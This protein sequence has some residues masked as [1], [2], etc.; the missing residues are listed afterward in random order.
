MTRQ[1]WSKNRNGTLHDRSRNSDQTLVN[2]TRVHEM[3]MLKVYAAPLLEAKGEVVGATRA[4]K[5]GGGD[6]IVSGTGMGEAPGSVG[7]QL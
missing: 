5:N 1:R 4:N 2:R 3:T 7:Y 6:P